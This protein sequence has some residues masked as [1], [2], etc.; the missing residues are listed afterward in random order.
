M[1]RIFLAGAAAC[2]FGSA[3]MAEITITDPYARASMPGAPS[4]AAFMVIENSAD[5]DDRLID[6][7][8]D[9]AAR[10]ELHTHLADAQGVM[11][12][13]E[14]E[15]GFVIPGK[16]R[17]LLG[18]GGDH[19]MFMGLTRTLEQGDTVAVTLVFE[20]A[21]EIPV[22]I[23]VDLE[24]MPTHGGDPERGMKHGMPDTE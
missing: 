17:H 5:T 2:V 23:P 20:N 16:D 10:V 1:T 24:R 12:M 21:G 22:E 18:R 19:V 4:G 7:R 15:D 13:R 9:V 11:R 6:V 14:V 3:A 8:S